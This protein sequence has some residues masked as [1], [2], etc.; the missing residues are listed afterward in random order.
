MFRDGEQKILDKTPAAISEIKGIFEEAENTY[1]SVSNEGF[2]N[3]GRLKSNSRVRTDDSVKSL[4]YQDRNTS[5]VEFERYNYN[6]VSDDYY[7]D[8][9]GGLSNNAA[10]SFVL[11]IVALLA[12]ITLVAVVTLGILNIIGYN[13]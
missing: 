6:N 11:V 1:N 13:F 8:N 5:D 7:N 3:E 4:G 12:L 9:L 2:D 10:V